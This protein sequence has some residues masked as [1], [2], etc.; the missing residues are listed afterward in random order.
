MWLIKAVAGTNNSIVHVHNVNLLDKGPQGRQ[1]VVY[2]FDVKDIGNNQVEALNLLLAPTA[3]VYMHIQAY[4]GTVKDRICFWE[5]S[6][7]F[8]TGITSSVT[9]KGCINLTTQYDPYEM[10]FMPSTLWLVL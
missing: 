4:N 9:A 5:S 1:N 7:W 6:V 8:D 2:S 3:H 10:S